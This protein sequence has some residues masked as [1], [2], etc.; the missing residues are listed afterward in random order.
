[1]N[2]GRRYSDSRPTGFRRPLDGLGLLF[3]LVL[4]LVAT[5]VVLIAPDRSWG[6]EMWPLYMGAMGVLLWVAIDLWQKLR[7]QPGDADHAPF[8]VSD[9]DEA[10]GKPP[11]SL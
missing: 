4:A 7:D 10:R 5:A 1:M 6:P 3:A 2:P 9:M 8:D 11:G